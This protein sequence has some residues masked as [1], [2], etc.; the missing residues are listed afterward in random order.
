MTKTPR[1]IWTA[2][3]NPDTSLLYVEVVTAGEVLILCHDPMP[4]FHHALA[5]IGVFVFAFLLVGGIAGGESAW[6]EGFEDSVVSWRDAGGNTQYRFEQHHRVRSE[7]NTG[8]GSEYLRVRSDRGGQVLLSHETGYPRVI[9]EL[10]LTVQLKSN[11]S[12]LQLSARVVFPRTTDPRTSQ[13]VV[14]LVAGSRYTRV[15]QWQQIRVGDIPRLAAREASRQL[16]PGVTIDQREAYVDRVLLN[17]CGG[18]GTTD[19]WI[20]DLDISGFVGPQPGT[21]DLQATQARLAEEAVAR[22]DR[23]AAEQPARRRVEMAG[24]VLVADQHPMFPRMVQYQGESLAFLKRLGFNAIW[25]G[26]LPSDVLL[27][28]AEQLGL[29]LICPPPGSPEVGNSAAPLATIGGRYDRVLAWDLGH[30]LSSEELSSTTHRA[31][32]VR[33]A[34]SDGQRPLVCRPISAL[35]GYSRQVDALLVGRSPLGTSLELPEYATWIGRR[36]RLARPGTPLWTTVQTQPGEAWRRQLAALAPGATPQA[37]VSSEQIRLLALTSIGAGSR[38]LLFLSDT[39]LEGN[40]WES[41]YRAAALRL[42]NLELAL[43]EPLLATGTLAAAVPG[44]SPN[45][46]VAVVRNKHAQLLLP[47]WSAPGAQWVPGQSAG[48]GVSFVVPGVPESDDAYELTPGGLKPLPHQRVT[49]GTRITLEEFGLATMIL[50]TQ[51]PLVVENVTQW[52]VALGAETARLQRDL[53]ERKLHHV[54][55]IVE[56]LPPGSAVPRRLEALLQ[57]AHH[58]LRRADGYLAARQWR[59]AYEC[60]RRAMR[61]TRLVERGYWEAATGLLDSPARVPT[62]ASFSSL[63]LHG[64]WMRRVRSGQWGQ[65]RLVGGDFENLQSMLA[66]G[67]Q[68]LQHPSPLVQSRADLAANAAHS[69]AFGLKLSAWAVETDEPVSVVESA[70]IWITSPEVIVTPGT[71]V[72]IH[73]WIRILQPIG[74]SVDGVQVFDPFSGQELARR[75]HRTAGWEEFTLDRVATEPGRVAVTVALTGLG[76]VWLDD[77]TIRVL[78]E[79][80]PGGL[81]RRP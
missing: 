60:A 9:D 11:R 42:L 26:E 74:G 31:Q 8:T 29:W 35:R 76:D 57:E 27:D 75:Y 30:G 68:H 15:G 21:A 78:H 1:L 61:S 33:L 14:V 3:T 5:V 55:R 46:S 36:G 51:E 70:P 69:G 49:G 18:P 13:P 52:S 44:N 56:Q 39:S 19:V 72:R 7:S 73:G 28:E 12:G 22:R 48:N 10:L 53:A 47:I 40:D 64:S 45:V 6:Y 16:T 80:V 67:W 17:V 62:A 79:T 41:R 2:I 38:G 66:T 24:P 50:L 65:S 54:S 77:V 43:V 81:T 37:H 34:D 71:L 63:P 32:Q 20:D 4:R 59:T 25:F 23:T 58:T